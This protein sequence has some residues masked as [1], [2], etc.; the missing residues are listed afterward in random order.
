MNKSKVKKIINLIL[1]IFWMIMIFSFSNQIGTNSSGLSNK[2]TEKIVSI[3]HITKGCTPENEK[4]VIKNIEH[5]IRKL[6][7]YSV[8]AL[9]GFL[10]YIEL[11]Q[12][13]IKLINRILITQLLGSIYAC[14]DE[15]HQLYIPG[16]SGEIRDVIID[17]C[18]IFAGILV[19]III[20]TLIERIISEIK[21]KKKCES[22]IN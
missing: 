8:Y 22:K 18:G 15:I 19:A 5:I 3:L 14:T 10:I 9:G 21:N 13:K 7:H 1:I 17:S 12:F 11:Y 4:K 16:R 6:A 2:V 20:I